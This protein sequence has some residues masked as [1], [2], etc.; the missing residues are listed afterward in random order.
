MGDPL[1][2]AVNFGTTTAVGLSVMGMATK[3]LQNIMPR[4]PRPRKYKSRSR[5]KRK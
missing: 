3:G 2:D 1:S 5:R 4:S